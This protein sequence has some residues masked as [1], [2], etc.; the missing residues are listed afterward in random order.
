MKNLIQQGDHITL[1]APAAIAGGAAVLIG[2][3]FGVAQGDADVGQ[4]VVLVRRGVFRLPKVAAQAWTA[5]AS[6][7]WD[8]AAA[9]LTTTATGNRLVGVA[10]DAAANPS[11]SA[12]V[13]LDG[14][15][16]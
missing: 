4:P 5:G 13:L 16:R 1:P 6:V 15:I 11:T 2:S 14:A 7:F 12:P 10:V 9:V 8:S 3:I